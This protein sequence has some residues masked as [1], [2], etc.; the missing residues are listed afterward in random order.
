MERGRSIPGG[1][2]MM[3]SAAFA[4]RWCTAL[5]LLVAGSGVPVAAQTQADL[6]DDTTLHTV[7][8]V[9][10]S[11][12]WS[13]L[14]ANFRSNDHYPC[15]V[16]WNG[17]R[18][19][20]VAVRSRGNGS[21][22]EAKP[23]LEL[24]FDHYAPQQRFLG[25]RG[26]V[27]DNLVTDPSMIREST[28]MALMRRVGVAAPREAPARVFVNGT[29]AGLYMMVEPV[30]TVFAQ[31]T[32]DQPGL[33]FEYRWTYPFFATFPG[34]ALDP[35]AVLFESRSLGVHS[36]AELY[37]PMR[38][39]FR[40]INEA[41]DGAFGE[42]AR[43]LDLTAL[44]RT[45]GASTFMAEW[46]GVFGYDGMN[47]F[48]LYRIGEQAH[49]IPWDRDQAFHALDYPLLAGVV[50]N[51][52]GRRILEDP[53][54]RSAYIE[55]VSEA[56]AAA[57]GDAWLEREFTRQYQLIHDAAVADTLKLATNESFE[58]AFT[59]LIAFARSRPSF[60]RGELAAV[61]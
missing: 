9:M 37:A 25:L 29:Y 41:P 20:N 60:V 2:V 40:T 18:M 13:D 7:E 53:V 33:L 11:R 22:Y 45:L 12:D 59:E 48:Y 54:L 5:A 23:G 52:L 31:K 49:L 16:I 30:D 8:I 36:V 32:F 61:R 26:L 17:V 24:G 58:A 46:D 19:R 43:Y 6:F 34:E 55:A 14:H 38:E 39:L 51:V 44:V 3:N 1:D 21:R 28:A 56:M 50:E 27:L 35:Y 15:D 42:V 10:H 57:E 47:N 4:T